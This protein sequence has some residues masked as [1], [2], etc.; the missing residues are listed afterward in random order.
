[1][2]EDE[3]DL[4]SSRQYCVNDILKM[5]VGTERQKP[6]TCRFSQKLGHSEQKVSVTY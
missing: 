2:I 3:T 4:R 1:M 5:A 6:L